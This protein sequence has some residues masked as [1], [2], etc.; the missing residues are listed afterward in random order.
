MLFSYFNVKC[1][2]NVT[3]I[4]L[5]C[6]ML[7]GCF[8]HTSFFYLGSLANALCKYQSLER[9]L[10]LLSFLDHSLIEKK[11]EPGSMLDIRGEQKQEQK[12]I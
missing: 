8:L 12:R 3:V 11:N 2:L 7:Q 4:F 6:M 1:L 9:M 5:Y 10:Y